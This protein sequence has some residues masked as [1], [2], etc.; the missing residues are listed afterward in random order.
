MRASTNELEFAAEQILQICRCMK[1]PND[2]FALLAMVLPLVATMAEKNKEGAFKCLDETFAV[3]RRELAA[4]YDRY[5]AELKNVEARQEEWERAA[6][7]VT[8]TLVEWI[9]GAPQK[10]KDKTR[11]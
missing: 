3:A 1:S 6:R 4:N 2:A 8:D 7:R 5:V 10:G 9:E 11:H